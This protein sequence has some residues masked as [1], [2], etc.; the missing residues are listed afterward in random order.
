MMLANLLATLAVKKIRLKL[1]NNNTILLRVKKNILDE[2]LKREIS[3]HKIEIIGLLKRNNVLTTSEKDIFSF[4]YS[5]YPLSSGQARIYFHEMLYPGTAV[6][7][8]PFVAKFTQLLDVNKL[9]NALNK[10]VSKHP[11]LRTKFILVDN[12][13]EQIIDTSTHPNL[14]VIDVNGAIDGADVVDLIN[15]EI[16]KPFNLEQG[17]LIRLKIIRANNQNSIMIMML[18]HIITDAWSE[19]II[20]KDLNKFYLSDDVG[21]SKSTDLVNMGDFALYEAAMM[22]NGC[23]KPVLNKIVKKL[24]F[25]PKELDFQIHIQDQEQDIHA[26]KTYYFDITASIAKKIKEKAEQLNTSVASILLAVYSLLIK[27]FVQQDRI[28]IGIAAAQRDFDELQHTVGFLVNTVPLAIDFTKIT[29]VEDYIK[30]CHNELMEA[31]SFANIPFDKLVEQFNIKRA[32]GKSPLVQAMFTYHDLYQ[33]EQLFGL[34]YNI[35]P[36]DIQQ[37]KFAI[38]AG[39]Y[40]TGNDIK[41]AFEFSPSVFYESQIQHMVTNYKYL[42]ECLVKSSDQLLEEINNRIKSTL[43][44]SGNPVQPS[45]CIIQEDLQRKSDNNESAV[46]TKLFCIWSELLEVDN[47][48]DDTN[49]F[50][51]GGNSL[52]AIKFIVKA[53]EMGIN[54]TLKQIFKNQTIAKICSDL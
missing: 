7:N 11:G 54:I 26:G 3:Q 30:L 23:W 36:S 21:K 35:L 52:L 9:Q 33:T 6:Y 17:S 5:R 37:A 38:T 4:G 53:R 8:V 43:I 51:I 42:I 48:S 10:L 14:E 22:Q 12:Y 31:L 13:P 19:G 40:N 2:D 50:D 44:F 47:I 25:F 39:F 34:P 49:F 16:K 29:T 46:K 15:K 18:H 20:L 28:I 27:N 1:E 41:A 32:L 45:S 24:S